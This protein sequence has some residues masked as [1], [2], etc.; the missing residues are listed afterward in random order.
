VGIR[1]SGETIPTN[2]VMFGSSTFT[3]NTPSNLVSIGFGGETAGHSVNIG[4][5]TKTGSGSV[6][7][8]KQTEATG[9]NSTA[10]GNSAVASGDR[11]FAGGSFSK[12]TQEKSTAIGFEATA[13]HTHSTAIGA[14]A[15]TEYDNTIVLGTKDDTV[16]IPGKLVV[17]QATLIGRRG[18]NGDNLY[19]KPYAREDGRH[20]AALNA[21]DWKGEDSNLGLVQ[22]AYNTD[23]LYV[24]VGPYL[25]TKERWKGDYGDNNRV[26]VKFDEPYSTDAGFYKYSDLRLKNIGDAFTGGL[27]EINKMNLYNYTFKNDKAKVPQVGIIAQDLQK[28]FPNSVVTAD[29]G[30]LKIRWDEILFSAV[31][32]IK[33]LDRKII[34]LAEK[35]QN[36]TNELVKLKTTVEAQQATIEAQTQQLQEQ[37]AELKVLST[38]I[39]K[40]EARKK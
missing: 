38:K 22:N 30:Y 35:V 2:S 31:N 7:V 39:E 20:F 33:E 28:I 27:A 23:E 3:S 16:Y 17:D 1:E 9:M 18:A 24:K 5:W 36:N 37:Q 8:G 14:G 13:K 11:A 40:L 21:G 32:A 34:A 6:A 10:I 4:A 19:F 29:D 26:H 15:T 25:T 12:A